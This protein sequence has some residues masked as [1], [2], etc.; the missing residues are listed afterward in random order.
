MFDFFKKFDM[1]KVSPSFSFDK[2]I[3]TSTEYGGIL[4]ITLFM[5]SILCIVG[6]GLDMVKRQ[7]P[8]V[9]ASDTF[10]YQLP[11]M[12]REQYEFAIAIMEGNNRE[13]NNLERA[14]T[15]TA[16]L[17]NRTTTSTSD[18]RYN[19]IKCIDDEKYNS[20]FFNSVIID[21]KNYYCLPKNINHTLIG[22]SSKSNSFGMRIEVNYCTNSTNN[23]SCYE[24]PQDKFYFV[25]FIYKNIHI[26]NN[27]FENPIKT[28]FDSDFLRLSTSFDTSF[29]YTYSNLDYSSDNGIIL[30]S[31]N[32]YSD[33][34]HIKTDSN[35]SYD[36]RSRRL[37]YAVI[38]MGNLK[39]KIE[40]YYQKIQKVAADV[41]GII[42]FF[43]IIFTFI[44]SRYS[45]LRFYSNFSKFSK[46]LNISS[47]FNL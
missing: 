34:M 45:D 24:R 42:E 27:D 13:I 28:H 40:R 26:D 10:M 12:K 23:T 46:G 33:N 41:G 9:A 21:I 11:E 16:I 43:S 5:L 14:F 47:K 31:K 18:N 22:S 3:R 29:R 19:L 35:A 30:K 39:K 4:S 38:Q 44:S 17:T 32:I 15:I 8:I 2:E 1:S 6:F 25:H 37:F 7:N 20:T 36:V